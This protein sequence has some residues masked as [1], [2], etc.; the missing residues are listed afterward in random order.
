MERQGAARG[1]NWEAEQKITHL[2]ND[3]CSRVLEVKGSLGKYRKLAVESGE[4]NLDGHGG[5]L[6]WAADTEQTARDAQRTQKSAAL[7]VRS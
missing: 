7:V 6:D 5:A 1:E 3:H 2:L 4:L